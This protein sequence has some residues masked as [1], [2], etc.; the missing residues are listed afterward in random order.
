MQMLGPEGLTP[1]EIFCDS[2]SRPGS[3]ACRFAS[4]KKIVMGRLALAYAPLLVPPGRM[5]KPFTGEPASPGEKAMPVAGSRRWG[6]A[7]RRQSL[8]WGGLRSAPRSTTL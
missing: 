8:R 4:G 2:G 7:E 1:H 6:R 3:V 5:G